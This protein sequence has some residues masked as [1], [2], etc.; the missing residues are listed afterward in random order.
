MSVDLVFYSELLDDLKT[1]IR[2]SQLKA[3]LA[4]NAEMILLYWDIGQMIHKR[5]QQEG[6]GTGVIPRLSKDIRNELPELKG[7]SERNIGYMIRFARGYDGSV[8]LQ[9]PVAKLEPDLESPVIIDQ[10]PCPRIVQDLLTKS[11]SVG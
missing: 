3:S 4:V 11:C 7:F 5:Q 9:Q 2:R 8:I 1:R 10:S 6:W